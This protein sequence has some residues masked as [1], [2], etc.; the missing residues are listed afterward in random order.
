MLPFEDRFSRQRQLS[1]VGREGQQRLLAT[2]VLVVP[3]RSAWI[4]LTYLQRAGV[5]ATLGGRP[6]AVCPPQ[7]GSVDRAEL[8]SA[9]PNSEVERFAHAAYFRHEASRELGAGAWRAL[10]VIRSVLG[11]P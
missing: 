2:E 1:E 9:Q 4:E 5:C 3:S 8:D 11:A 10:S 6:D 7:L